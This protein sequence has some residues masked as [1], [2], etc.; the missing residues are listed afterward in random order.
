MVAEDLDVLDARSAAFGDVEGQANLVA[1]HGGNGG[2]HLGAVKA[3]VDVLA[4]ELLLDPVDQR[5]VVRPPRR[6]PG[7]AQHT[8]QDVVAEFLVAG[9]IHG[10]DGGA[11]LHVDHEHIA[12]HVEAHVGEQAQAEQRTD[13]RGAFFIVVGFAHTYRQRREHG[14]RLD[15]LQALDTDV[16]HGERV[17]RPG[18]LRCKGQRDQRGHRAQAESL[19]D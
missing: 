3:L 1:L 14:A 10:S 19:S 11:L 15:A 8:L 9:E 7:V 16:A 17:N 2:H 5:A 12:L 4:L 13:G 18:H 6:Q